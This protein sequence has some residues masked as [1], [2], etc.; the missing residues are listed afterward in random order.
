[1]SDW[2]EVPW[3]LRI[4]VQSL[5]FLVYLVGMGIRALVLA[6]G[7]AGAFLVWDREWG[8][9]IPLGISVALMWSDAQNADDPK[10]WLSSKSYLK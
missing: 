6:V 10:E 8:G 4:K 2:S 9:L 5:N 1:M 7:L 3:G